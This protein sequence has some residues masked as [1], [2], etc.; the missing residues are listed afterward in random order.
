MHMPSTI[1]PLSSAHPP[2]CRPP[3]LLRGGPRQAAA[4]AVDHPGVSVQGRRAVLPGPQVG[5]GLAAGLR[6][7]VG[8]PRA[9]AAMRAGARGQQGSAPGLRGFAAP[10][11]LGSGSPNAACK[12]SPPGL[13]NMRFPA[14]PG[15]LPPPLPPAC[16]RYERVE[17]GVSRGVF[18]D[19]TDPTLCRVTVRGEPNWGEGFRGLPWWGRGGR[20][21]N[22]TQPLARIG[23]G[24]PRPS[25]LKA[26]SPAPPPA[27]TYTCLADDAA[28]NGG[29]PSVIVALC[30]STCGPRLQPCKDAM[31]RPLPGPYVQGKGRDGGGGGGGPGG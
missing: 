13:Y 24:H 2:A 7:W 12:R 22:S 20:R 15:S 31:P 11:C 9:R 16:R 17:E 5:W 3:A 19:G 23:V 21:R 6:P 8:S 4:G 27:A 1:I 18:Y 30:K 26:P 10:P 28:C 25:S 29:D 14:S